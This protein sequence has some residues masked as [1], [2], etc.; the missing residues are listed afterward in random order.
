MCF[1]VR[2]G[3]QVAT[4]AVE[5]VV[6]TCHPEQPQSC[7]G[8][9]RVKY[10]VVSCRVEYV[11]CQGVSDGVTHVVVSLLKKPMLQDSTR[12]DSEYILH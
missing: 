5:S 2:D 9:S 8:M 10:V 7:R 11:I 12:L 1:R 4:R 6:W 3:T